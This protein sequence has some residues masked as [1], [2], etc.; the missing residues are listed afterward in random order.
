MILGVFLILSSLLPGFICSV[1]LLPFVLPFERVVVLNFCDGFQK[2]GRGGGGKRFMDI[3]ILVSVC[4][5]I[6]HKI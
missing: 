4:V 6:L 5:F 1:P 2:E 3:Y